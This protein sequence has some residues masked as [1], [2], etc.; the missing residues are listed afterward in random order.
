MI[1]KEDDV[2]E[3]IRANVYIDND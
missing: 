3:Y 2:I 1:D